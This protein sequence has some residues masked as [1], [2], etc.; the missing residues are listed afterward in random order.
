M[1]YGIISDIHAN[2]EALTTVL[3]RCEQL[4]V[5]QYICIGDIVGYNANPSECLEII[6][7]LPLAAIVKGNHDEQ[8][9]E[10]LDLS[11]FNSQAAQAIE[12]TRQQLSDEQR[13]YLRELPIKSRTGRISVVHA[14]LDNPEDWG[15]IMD[16]FAAEASLAYQFSQICFYGHSHVPMA[17]D[18]QHDIEL[19]QD[20]EFKILP[21][22]KYL[23]NP[24]SVGQPRD[25]DPRASF[26][27][28]DTEESTITLYRLE[29]DISLTQSKIREN[30]LPERLAERLAIGH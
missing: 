18:K 2:L 13:Q 30:G 8:A 17:F 25:K 26:A 24:G 20:A 5:S 29:Y 16:S 11:E 4:G 23:V 3:D 14:T 19:V 7:S 10:N 9:S 15:Y 1:K 21:G 28:Y 22:H 12:W 27:V 6:R